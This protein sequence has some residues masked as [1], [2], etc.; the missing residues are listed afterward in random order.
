MR[1]TNQTLTE[2]HV[3]A[4]AAVKNEQITRARVE[5]IEAVLSRGFWGR[6][7]WLLFGR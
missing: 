7:R 3:N 5:R 2:A 6:M 4:A 1:V